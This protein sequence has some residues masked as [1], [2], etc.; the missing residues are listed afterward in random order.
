MY[1]P[2]KG[3]VDIFML[4]EGP[5]EAIRELSASPGKHPSKP[6]HYSQE[7]NADQVGQEGH[8][9]LLKRKGRQGL[10]APPVR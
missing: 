1:R 10:S 6:T 4:P 5:S 8:D 9:R 3:Q 7:V 2:L